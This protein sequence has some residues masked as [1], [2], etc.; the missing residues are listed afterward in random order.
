MDQFDKQ[1]KKEALSA[2]LS[3]WWWNHGIKKQDFKGT[4]REWLQENKVSIRKSGT[5]ITLKGDYGSMRL[6]IRQSNQFTNCFDLYIKTR[7]TF[8]GDKA[9]M[10]NRYG[11]EYKINWR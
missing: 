7:L 8:L 2:T 1:Q 11:V 6:S 4:Y 9:M 3:I 5:Y 10:R